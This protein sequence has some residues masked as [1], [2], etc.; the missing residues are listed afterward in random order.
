M[1]RIVLIILATLA[2]LW[3]IKCSM[4]ALANVLKRRIQSD[5]RNCGYC[6]TVGAA[7]WIYR[8]KKSGD[9]L[10]VCSACLPTKLGLVPI[11]WALANGYLTPLPAQD[12]VT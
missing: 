2:G 11:D 12:V 5:I 4:V 9:V 1:L 7:L 3:L 10:G 8:S 6:Y